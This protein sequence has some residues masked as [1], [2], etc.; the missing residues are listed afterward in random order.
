[1][2]VRGGEHLQVLRTAF[3]VLSNGNKYALISGFSSANTLNFCTKVGIIELDDSTKCIVGISGLHSFANPAQQIPGS[4]VADR[5]P[6]GQSQCGDAALV[7][8]HQ[9]DRPKPFGQRQMCPVHD[10]IGS[11]RGLMTAVGT[12]IASG[13]IQR[14]AMLM[15]ANRA[16]KALWPLNAV[17][18]VCTG[19]FIGKTLEKLSITHG[20]LDGF[21]C[22][23]FLVHNGTTSTVPLSHTS[24]PIFRTY[25]SSWALLF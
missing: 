12:L 15:T 14:I 11:E 16:Y 22:C 6:P 20:L 18:I 24:S 17:Q 9:I 25:T 5:D 21:A 8:G 13:T 3:V 7:T 19:F 4:F 1:M 10:G 2:N 23:F